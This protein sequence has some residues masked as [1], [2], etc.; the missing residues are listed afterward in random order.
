[1]VG[2]TVLILFYKILTS[3]KITALYHKF[4]YY[5]MDGGAFVVEGDLT[6][7]AD[8]FLPCKQKG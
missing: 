2:L 3:G 8:S 1:M 5:T 7:L 6:L 4:L